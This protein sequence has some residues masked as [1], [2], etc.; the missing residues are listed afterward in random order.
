MIQVIVKK[1]GKEGG[2]SEF[3]FGSI[4]FEE[5]KNWSLIRQKQ[6]KKVWKWLAYKDNAAETM[7]VIENSPRVCGRLIWVIAMMKGQLKGEFN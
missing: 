1:G 3:G 5:L 4:E 2:D 7:D 6:E